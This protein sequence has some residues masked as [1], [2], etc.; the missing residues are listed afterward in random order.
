MANRWLDYQNSICRVSLGT[1]FNVKDYA[2]CLDNIKLYS[3]KYSIAVY[4]YVLMTNYVHLRVIPE[5]EQ[6]VSQI[7]QALGRYYFRYIS[8]A[9][10]RAGA[11]WE[12][13]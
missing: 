8:K 9:Y 4:S 3:K 2:V 6:G 7:M 10:E 11:L 12:G 1:L 5:S 13:L